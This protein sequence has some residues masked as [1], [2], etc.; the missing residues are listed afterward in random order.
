MLRSEEQILGALESTQ[1][2]LGIIQGWEAS[3]LTSD[4]VVEL[5]ALEARL[6]GAEELHPEFVK[7]MAR[8]LEWVLGRTF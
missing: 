7:G 5:F 4:E 8:T 1:G 3:G 6:E 2:L